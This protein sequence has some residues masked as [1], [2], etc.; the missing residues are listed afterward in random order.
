MAVT[1]SDGRRS[2]PIGRLLL[3]VALVALAI[4]TI[5]ILLVVFLAVILAI[6]LDAITDQLHRRLGMP[7]ARA[8]A[9]ARRYPRRAGRRRPAHR[10]A[11]DRSRCRTCSPTC[12]ATS[13]AST[14]T[15]TLFIRSIPVLRRS[16]TPGAEGQPGLLANALGE[17]LG[18]LRG[19]AVPYLKGGVEVLIEGV[20]VLVMAI[21]LA[22]HPA[23]YADGVVALVPP[24][25]AAARAGHPAGS[26]RHDPRLGGGADHRHGAARGAH[27]A[28][29]LGARHA[30]FP[31][32]RR[33]RRG[34]GHRA[35]L[36][37]A[38]VDRAARA[39]RPGRVRRDQG[40]AGGRAG[41]GG[42]PHRGQLRGARS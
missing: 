36:R 8:R 17:I 1:A 20:S 19:A 6:Y 31:R 30:L 27:D 9:A 26:Q 18:F 33:L 3:A 25:A 22:R 42:P 38:A 39:L 40:A 14:P 15:S 35:L 28:R 24:R 10:A 29:P 11:G 16:A 12:R 37:R 4:K 34:R 7:T 13:P 32:L 21:F 41:R 2:F 5:D 23:V